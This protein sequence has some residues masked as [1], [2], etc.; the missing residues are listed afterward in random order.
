[1]VDGGD[2]QPPLSTKTSQIREWRSIVTLIVFVITNVVVLFPF[3]VPIPIPRLLAHGF[4][5]ALS[6]LR[7]I[8]PRLEECHDEEKPIKQKPYVVLR[9]P[10]NFV[11][12]PLIADL[13]LLAIL[14]IGKTEVR[15]GTLGTDN[16]NPLDIMVF[17]LSLA[18][19]A[20]SLDASGL[21]RYLAFRVLKWGGDNGPRLYF[22]LYS[23]FFA[24]TS[25]IGN[26]PIILSGTA[27]LAYMT[28][29]SSNIVHPRAWIHAQFA[30]ANIASAILVSSNPTNLVLVGAFH[31]RFIKYTANVIVPVI[32]TGIVLFPFLL[33]LIF[34]NQE[35]IPSD[36][37]MHELPDE[38]KPENK[39]AV[40]PNIPHA[41]GAAAE[42]ERELADSDVDNE[43]GKLLSL[44][45]ILNPFLD[46][47]GA[48]FGGAIMA[49]TLVTLLAL[50]AAA[51]KLGEHPVFWVTLPAAVVQFCW[52]VA[53]GWRDR[54]KTRELA[55]KGREE[56]RRRAE[57]KEAAREEEERRTRAND[58]SHLTASHARLSHDACGSSRAS[59]DGHDLQGKTPLDSTHA[60]QQASSANLNEDLAEKQDAAG[61]EEH[62]LREKKR[63]LARPT[64]VSQTKVWY[65]WLQETFPTATTVMAHLPLALVPFAFTMFVLVQALV[66]KGWVPVFAHGWDH[67]V[68][69]TG[70]I[71]A[72]GG[73]GFLSVVLCNFAGTN[74]GTTILL[75]RVIQTW[76]QIH[77]ENGIPISDRTFWGTVYSM[78]IGVNYGAFSAAFSASLA[79]LL[80]RDILAR[81]H[82]R[83]HN[84]DFARINLPIIAISMTVGL[85][86]LVGQIYIMRGDQ[87]YDGGR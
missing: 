9:F 64:L 80:W 5:D 53:L 79:G 32:V 11:T 76:Q 42:E 44:E 14:A 66:T 59:Q 51:D 49:I 34:P 58:P 81:K 65:E 12:A 15:G 16:I 87:P 20:I 8:A 63:H 35:L 21:I 6:A 30:V 83:V 60:S 1:M 73:M 22:Y 27:F 47:K 23:F 19:I 7:I 33:Y 41:R 69:K 37:K 17:F 38:L 18:Y 31:V 61:S 78:A 70:T 50:N 84:L 4:L 40:N 10:L 36:I 13:F 25:F 74:I 26:D 45:E 39:E 48:G 54:H 55:A 71:G 28:R 29:V 46:K 57:E 62:A 75:S 67:W 72:I 85:V 2:G 86:V 24:L 43:T 82:I 77:H 52:D 3:H 56:I 68:D